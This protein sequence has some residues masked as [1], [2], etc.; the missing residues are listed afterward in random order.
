VATALALV[1]AG[2]SG[3]S[4]ASAGVTGPAF[5]VDG[6]AY[7]TVG[8]PNDLSGTGGPAHSFDTIFD[9]GGNQLNVATAAPGDRDY[10][11]G[12]WRVHAL[13]FP[14]G[15]AAAVA[16]GDVD[17]DGVIDSSAELDLAFAAGAAVDTGVVKSFTCPVI[18]LPSKR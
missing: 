11:G 18:E 2:F 5:Y 16:A 10:D 4:P 12:R 6:A 3:A 1:A 15:H 8:T 7:R 13:S 9:F 17:G 14:S